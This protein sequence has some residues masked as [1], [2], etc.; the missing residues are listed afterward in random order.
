MNSWGFSPLIEIRSVNPE[1]L[2]SLWDFQQSS[3][4][5]V[6]VPSIFT[7]VSSRST[8]WR[9]WKHRSKLLILQLTLSCSLAWGIS[10]FPGGILLE[11]K[12]GCHL[13]RWCKSFP[14]SA[15]RDQA[16]WAECDGCIPTSLVIRS[17]RW[18]H[19]V[20]EKRRSLKTWSGP[21]RTGWASSIKSDAEVSSSKPHSSGC[22]WHMPVC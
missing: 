10:H 20:W 21:W 19:K 8:Q 16:L 18:L 11:G 4:C 14:A 3:A 1:D 12:A 5:V 15:C 6:A 17:S 9:I 13:C 2:K 7:L 22:S